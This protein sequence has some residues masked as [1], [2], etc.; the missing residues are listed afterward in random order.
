MAEN[1]AVILADIL[2]QQNPQWDE[3]AWTRLCEMEEYCDA[4]VS[5]PES[6][7]LRCSDCG[8]FLTRSYSWA[9]IYAHDGLDYEHF[10]CAR[11]TSK[12]GPALSN[13]RPIDVDM[14]PYQGTNVP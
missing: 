5:W 9:N 14:T 10:R 4:P 3:F 8:S 2:S 13:A 7:R 12:L 1:P 11:C 6:N